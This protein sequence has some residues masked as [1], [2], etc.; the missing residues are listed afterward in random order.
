MRFQTLWQFPHF[1]ALAWLHRED[2]TRGG[3]KMFPMS[4]TGEETAKLIKPYFAKFCI[5]LS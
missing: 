3:F 4:M 5:S 1:Y 2:Y